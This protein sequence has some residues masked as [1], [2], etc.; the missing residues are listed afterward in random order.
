MKFSDKLA[1]KRKENNL[2]QEQL[3]DRLNM[4]RQAISKWESGSTYPDMN[5]II[6]LC[7]IFNCTLNE[8]L[9]DGVID[10]NSKIS[11]DSWVSDILD[12]ITKT[13]NMFC[14]MKFKDII[15]CLFEF[16]VLILILSLGFNIIG[17]IFN[18]LL[19]RLLGVLNIYPTIFNIYSFIYGVFVFIVISIIVIHLFKIRYLDYYILIED[20]NVAAKTKEEPIKENKEV[21]DSLF[22]K[23]REKIIIRDKEHTTYSFINAIWKVVLF[24]IK[25]FAT[26]IAGFFIFTFIFG[27]SS[28]V[29]SLSLIKYGIFFL[30]VA[31]A[32]L[33]ALS[34]NY[35]FLKILY[36]LI[37][38]KDYN[39]TSIFIVFILGLILIGLG[40]GFSFSNYLTFK[41]ISE[42]SDVK[43]HTET[44]KMNENIEF[45]FN[46]K[47]IID[48]TLDDIKIEIE[49]ILDEPI[50]ELSNYDMKT[51]YLHSTD[52]SFLESYKTVM[53]YFKNK[54]E[55]P[56]ENIYYNNPVK[57]YLSTENYNKLNK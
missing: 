16:I 21:K 52:Y 4:S 14:S 39:I 50:L 36:S 19:S 43:V 17:N 29:F 31:I 1:K 27:T 7:K 47:Y 33:G 6:E 30:G 15:K 49:Y 13:Y 5:T 38:N 10:N 45:G 40:I 24:G 3:A 57:I 2:S 41:P 8:L 22:Q 12:F 34:I 20:K 46:K 53:Y 44:I 9:D 51:Y 18:S 32:I 55:L 56:Y 35:V 25:I 48:D 37:L 42:Y 11:D 26:F 23:T 28:L 54:I